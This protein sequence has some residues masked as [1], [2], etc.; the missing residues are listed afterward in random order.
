MSVLL[1]ISRLDKKA[2]MIMIVARHLMLVEQ[3]FS[4]GR[5]ALAVGLLAMLPGCGPGHVK[6][7]PATPY[8]YRDRHPVVL[9]DTSYVVDLFPAIIGGRIDYTTAGRIREFVDHYRHFGH[10]PVTLRRP[11]GSAGAKHTDASIAAVRRT[12]TSAGVRGTIIVEDYRVVDPRLAAPMR[13][14]FSGLKAKV[15]GK[16][17]EWPTDLASGASLEGWQNES[18]W[19][20]GCATQ[21]TFAAQIA[22]PRDL[23]GPRGETPADTIA[24][25]RALDK[26]R[27]GEDPST[28]WPQE[29]QTISKVG[30]NL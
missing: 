25:M 22:D 1:T 13:L 5:M 11:V 14:S 20:Y 10:G 30:G 2:A 23:A 19:N 4:I 26:I 12:L 28:K 6:P 9:A 18:W 7:P 3:I 16:C 27:E 24:R 17:G 21:Q 29:Q 8:D 15:S